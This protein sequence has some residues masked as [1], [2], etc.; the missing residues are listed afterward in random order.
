[1][2]SETSPLN[3][4]KKEMWE[5][6]AKSQ[7][8]CSFLKYEN[9]F[10]SL[11][12]R[13]LSIDSNKTFIEVGASPGRNMV[14]FNRVFSYQVTGLDYVDNFDESQNNLERSNVKSFSLINQDLFDYKV[15]YQY[16]IVFSS[17]FIEHFDDWERTMDVIQKL[18]KPGGIVIT[19]CPHYRGFQYIIRKLLSPEVFSYHNLAM[20]KPSAFKNYYKN[21]NVEILYCDYFGLFAYWD[22]N[23]YKNPFRRFITRVLEK[24]SSYTKSLNY[25]NRFFSPHVL[26]IVKTT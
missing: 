20:M 17:G 25:P 11:L 4:A 14:Y 15:D 12:K 2:E 9:V 16:D 24:V 26:C 13:F 3:L 7:Y 18:V 6:V 22:Q 21:K 8:G 23:A 19:S 10:D 1:M 5:E